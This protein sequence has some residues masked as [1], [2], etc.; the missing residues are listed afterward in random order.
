[1]AYGSAGDETRETDMD[2]LLS[3][4][5]GSLSEESTASDGT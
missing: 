4:V 3:M 5:R 2:L 1:V